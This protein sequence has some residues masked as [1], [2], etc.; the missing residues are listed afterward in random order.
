MLVVEDGDDFVA[1]FERRDDLIEE[2][3]TGIHDLL[4]SRHAGIFS[5]LT[6]GQHSG[7]CQRV[8]PQ[9]EGIVNRLRNYEAVLSRESL[10]EISVAD[11]IDVQRHQFQVGTESAVLCPA[12]E[13]LA[14]DDV[15]V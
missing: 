11:L 10:A 7:D 5:M 13:N 2:P 12:F 15:S 4:S 6:D 14:H 1:L 3:P 9:C 8:A